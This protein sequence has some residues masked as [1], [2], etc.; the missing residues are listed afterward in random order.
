MED[1][2]KTRFEQ[3]DSSSQLDCHSKYQVMSEA[4]RYRSSRRF[5]CAILI[6]SSFYVCAL[7]LF[8][9]RLRRV[10]CR[11]KRS[12]LH[13]LRFDVRLELGVNLVHGLAGKDISLDAARHHS[14]DNF[15]KA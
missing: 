7:K 14:G 15:Q 9:T 12:T 13:A 1:L 2:Q 5:Y 3:S 6:G 11:K 4:I 8:I 10:M